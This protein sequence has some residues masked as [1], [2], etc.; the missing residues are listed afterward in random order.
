MR[1]EII[2]DAVLYCG[3][4]L[5][6]A[7]ELEAASIDAL[8]S[9]PP[10]GLE[11]MGKDWD[12][13]VPGVHFWEA[14]FW[15]VKPGAH[16]LAFGGT[17][18]FHRQVVAIEDA[19]WEI[20]DQL[21][22][23]YSTGFP[24]SMNIGCKCTTKPIPYHNDS[25][26]YNMRETVQQ[27]AEPCSKDVGNI[28]QPE[29]QRGT[30]GP[31]V[32]DTWSQG[33]GCEEN[34]HTYGRRK[35]P[36]MEGRGNV[37]EETRELQTNQVRPLSDG[38]CEHG[39]ERRLCHGASS[40]NGADDRQ[41]ITTSGSGSPYKPRPA[42]QQAGKPGT[43]PGQQNAQ[44]RG[45]EAEARCKV[46][47]GLIN[48][49]GWG[50]ALKPAWEPI[51]LARKPLVGTVAGNVLRF[52]TGAINV[53]GCR[54]EGEAWTRST[55]Y[56][57]N[58]KGGS[59]HAGKIQL[60]YECEPQSGNDAG[61]WPANIIHDGSD[62]VVGMFPAEEGASAA[63]FF[64]AAKASKD[65]RDE[66]LTGPERVAGGM[67]GRADGSLG[68]VTM[69]RNIHPTVK[70]TDLMR[71]CIRL[72]TPPGGIVFDPF[73]GSGSTGKAAMLEGK[74]FVGAEL[75]P[76]Y[77]DIACRRIEAAY[78]QAKSQPALFDE[79][80]VTGRKAADIMQKSLF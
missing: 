66:G 14:F 33:G 10:Y 45:S 38:S 15:V 54:V 71:W 13:G 16:L 74:R 62:E 9:D 4:C 73:M 50:T 7:A 2:G 17:R 46:C 11:F 1:R 22:W 19:G 12:R 5:D 42:G 34:I 40:N 68:S 29:M 27:A 67:S 30:K 36:G 55:P 76:E 31:G 21:G 39:K 52:G 63:R 56:K 80:Q 48:W 53:D 77:F 65:D 28:L 51:C 18:T 58:I 6:V 47:N 23:L 61:R 72:V 49:Q 43:I 69:R 57:D 59:L 24:K 70:P 79:L 64:Y 32:G 60:T 78:K 8:V 20:R 37:L 44:D 41:A 26:M 25:N 35:E 3:D 75:S